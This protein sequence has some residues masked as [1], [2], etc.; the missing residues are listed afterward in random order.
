[1]ITF[2]KLFINSTGFLFSHSLN[3]P[4]KQVSKL[5]KS[6]HFWVVKTLSINLQASKLL[7]NGLTAFLK[8]CFVAKSRLRSRHSSTGRSKIDSRSLTE[9]AHPKSVRGLA[10]RARTSEMIF[11]SSSNKVVKYLV[12]VSMHGMYFFKP[13]IF[14]KVAKGLKWRRVANRSY[15]FT[16]SLKQT[17]LT[18]A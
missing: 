12:A 4:R 6:L 1:M 7:A 10:T 18:S 3:C 13:Q 8:H 11:S 15:K 2:N 16:E 17:A 9:L 5:T 14:G